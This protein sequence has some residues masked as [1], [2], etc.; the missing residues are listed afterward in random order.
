MGS[1]VETDNEEKVEE[2]I[3][4]LHTLILDTMIDALE[5]LNAANQDRML[6]QTTITYI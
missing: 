2:I 4:L 6:Y 3:Q 5:K 1:K